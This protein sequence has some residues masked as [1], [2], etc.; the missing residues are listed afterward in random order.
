M[1]GFHI[2]VITYILVIND[3]TTKRQGL[4][5]GPQGALRA[6]FDLPA[7]SAGGSS[8]GG[9]PLR[10]KKGKAFF[11]VLRAEPLRLDHAERGRVIY[12]NKNRRRERVSGGLR[13]PAD[14]G[15]EAARVTRF[16]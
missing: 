16:I 7:R 11:G 4:F 9:A 8:G 2:L 10:L 13:P 15:G 12:F 5:G 1:K 6:P 14:V 3:K